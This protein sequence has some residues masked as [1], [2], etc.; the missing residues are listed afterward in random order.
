M[1]KN[2]NLILSIIIILTANLIW[3]TQSFAISPISNIDCQLLDATNYLSTQQSTATG[4]ITGFGGNSDW[5]SIG[6]VTA[7]LDPASFSY[8]SSPTIVQYLA[9]N[10]LDP[11]SSATTIEK[12]ILAINA[13][14]QDP[15]NFYGINY[16]DQ[17]LG[18]YQANQLGD[19]TLLNDDIFGIMALLGSNQTTQ[20]ALLDSLNYLVD[21]Q[22]PDGG[23]GYSLSSGSDTNDT[24]SAL[25]ALISSQRAGLTHPNLDQVIAGAINY[26]IPSQNLDGGFG[27]LPGDPS[28]G[29]STAW[30]LIALN[31]IGT[32]QDVQAYQGL[33]SQWL[34]DNQLSDG[35]FGYLAEYGSDTYTTSHAL[36]ALTGNTWLNPQSDQLSCNDQATDPVQSNSQ[37]TPADSSNQ[38]TQA[39]TGTVQ[40]YT[41]VTSLPNTGSSNLVS[42]VIVLMPLTA[43]L[44][45]ITRIAS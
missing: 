45:K 32:I 44:R 28:D 5:A 17:L 37:D 21:N 26:L 18:S 41:Q 27:Y 42:L 12:R 39:E 20:I 30:G 1:R 14:R 2:I 10:P 22:E 23:F 15:Q 31:A 7:G 19:P 8:Q 16:L 3:Q 9:S 6:L 43:I 13:L 25:V 33:A 29:S 24:A 4:E 38:T 35:G 11:A 36:I 34:I 40:G